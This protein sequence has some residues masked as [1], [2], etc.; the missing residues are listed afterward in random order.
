[1]KTTPV[2]ALQIEAQEPPLNLRRRYLAEKYIL[3]LKTQNR[4]DIL[5]KIAS[6]SI[7]D[8]TDK[9]W[10]KKISPGLAQGFCST[11]TYDQRIYVTTQ[12]NLD[13]F[14]LLHKET[15]IFPPYKNHRAHDA[16]LFLSIMEQV[17]NSTVIFTDGSKSAHGCGSAFYIYNSNV[18]RGFQLDRD[19][20]IFTAEAVAILEA[21]KYANSI[22]LKRITIMT[23]SR[24]VMQAIEKRDDVFRMEPVIKDIS[25]MLIGMRDDGAYIEIYWVKGHSDIAPNEE[26]DR[27]AKKSSTEGIPYKPTLTMKE[28][29]SKIK[30]ASSIYSG[31]G[32][33]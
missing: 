2:A 7:L 29:T 13:Y 14:S 24:S 11:S 33:G 31:T 22:Q 6:L 32:N 9:Y 25:K 17:K 21:L 28:L 8:L 3:K 30:K 1:M 20:S 19:T 27:L 23:D 10:R 4:T 12:S 5:N 26:V 15:I 18:N 16:K